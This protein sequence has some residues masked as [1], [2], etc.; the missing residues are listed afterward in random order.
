M[1]RA[2]QRGRQAG[3]TANGARQACEG[4]GGKTW[5][6]LVGYVQPYQEAYVWEGAD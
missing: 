6:P 4:G 1:V 3:A 5:G 2:G